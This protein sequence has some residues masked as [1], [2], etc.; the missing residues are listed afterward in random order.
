VSPAAPLKLG[1]RDVLEAAPDA[2][3]IADS[4]GRIAQ[5]NAHA[6]RLFDY[7][8][9]DLLGQPVEV[10]LPERF[11]QWYRSERASFLPAP[12]ASPVGAGPELYARRRDGRE[13]PVEISLSPI[14]TPRGPVV[15]CGIR[16]ISERKRAE[17]ALADAEER[18]RGVFER[19]PIGMAV[20]DHDGRLTL[21]NDALSQL[22]GYRRSRLVGMHIYSVM[23]P[24]DFGALVDALGAIR[25]GEQTLYKA[26][27]A[28]VHAAGHPQWVSLQVTLMRARDRAPAY[29]L[30]QLQD[31]TDRRRHE[32]KLRELAD[33]DP[34][35]GLL[36]RRSFTRELN[37]QA[38]LAGRYGP[39]GALLMLDLDHFKYVNDTVGHQAGD[40]VIVHVAELLTS[41]LRETDASARLGGDEFAVLLRKADTAGAERVADGL[42]EILRE[43][44]IVTAGLPRVITASIGVAMFEAE[45]SGEDVLVNA[46]LAMYHAKQAGRDRVAQ[47]S[48][49]R[50]PR[51]RTKGRLGWV[52]RIQKALADDRF[53]LLAQP[54]I[55]L[56][57]GRVSQHELLVRMRDE[58]GD[59]VSP[60]AFL[61]IAERIEM[62]QQIDAWVIERAGDLLHQGAARGQELTLE[63][64]LSGRSIGDPEL[65]ELIDDRIRRSGA[66]PWQLI[67]ETTETAA[68]EH[69]AKARR[70][71]ERL[72]ELGCRFALDDFGAGFGSFYYLKHMPFDI[73]KID[74][75]F[76]ESC[77]ASPTD[78]LVIKAIVEVARGLGKSTIAEFVGD[79][80]TVR[81]LAELGVDYGQG[82]YIG[83]PT[84]AHELI[85]ASAVQA[86]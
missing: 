79:E 14:E 47:F 25:R 75:E 35:T 66:A 42:L 12:P 20:I 32:D 17:D 2:L 34:L 48:D 85:V 50:D 24:E 54:V 5:L 65:I 11:H 30:C 76:I 28:F 15:I 43:E 39:E 9:A 21:V 73:V 27:N 19:A 56:A 23:H 58:H 7:E 22:T 68:V 26:E 60:G 83:R 53:S 55:D 80:G 70:F 44:L 62:V 69:I 16:D 31:V 3:V 52:Q 1:V 29:F 72:A 57:S 40:A 18:F 45:L 41:R 74:G 71:S 8:R 82:Y 84:P 6:E 46:D 10:L 38:A 51:A 86:G 64:N 61:C 78:R 4:G 36:N 77:L 81:L 59:L 67:F 49:Q 37:A 63:V 13:I 33:R